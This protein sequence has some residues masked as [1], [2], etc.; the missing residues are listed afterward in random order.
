M[1][2]RI[3]FFVILLLSNFLTI[4]LFSHLS[5]ADQI[6]LKSGQVLDATVLE[7]TPELI[8]V[9]SSS[10]PMSYPRD[11]VI[12]INSI[13]LDGE[14]PESEKTVTTENP[15]QGSTTE[16]TLSP[17][18]S[19]SPYET[20]S[21]SLINNL[22]TP[23]EAHLLERM[24][25]Q[26]KAIRTGTG[27][28]TPANYLHHQIRKQTRTY[29]TGYLDFLTFVE[30]VFPPF[31]RF[32]RSNSIFLKD[33]A[34]DPE[35]R[36]VLIY[37]LVIQFFIFSIALQQIAQRFRLTSWMAFIPI[38]QL[39]LLVK[40]ADRPLL[41]F[42]LL[43]VPIFNI[44]VWIMIWVDIFDLFQKPLPLAVFMLIPGLQVILPWY[45][46]ISTKDA[47]T[48]VNQAYYG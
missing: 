26:E 44:F 18:P 4:F 5:F 25:N 33:L 41:W 35:N 30:P 28:T 20:E 39:V 23:E 24:A 40:M 15:N 1:T 13:A 48:K 42:F 21:E 6:I 34:L 27:E 7:L 36:D 38:L 31:I 8:R 47:V 9:E 19:P 43:F 22:G 17:P 29:W 12:S 16:T 3:H 45:L 46:L 14:L 11:E 32:I 2:K 37:I 10:G